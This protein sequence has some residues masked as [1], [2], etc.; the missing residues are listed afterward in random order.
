MNR[1]LYLRT[2]VHEPRILDSSLRYGE[3]ARGRF[4]RRLA[5]QRDGLLISFQLG[6]QYFLDVNR[7]REAPDNF[8]PKV[9]RR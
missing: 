2:R 9:T 6:Q 8:R 7:Y 5:I 4:G 3:P 1:P